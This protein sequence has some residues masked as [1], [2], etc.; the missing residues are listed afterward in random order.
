PPCPREVMGF[1]AIIL[2]IF[3]A[4]LRYFSDDSGDAPFLEGSAGI[5]A[6]DAQRCHRA[7]G[8]TLTK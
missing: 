5:L 3:L 1:D 7:T 6:C 4:N 8:A 2:G